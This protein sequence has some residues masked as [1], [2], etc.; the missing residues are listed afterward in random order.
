M[1]ETAGPARAEGVWP[2]RLAL[3]ALAAALY[4]GIPLHR[5]ELMDGTGDGTP[6]VGHFELFARAF[7]HGRIG[8]VVG[9]AATVRIDELIPEHA[10]QAQRPG[11]ET[12]RL[13]QGERLY[14]GYPP[15][16]AFLLIPFVFLF[17][18]VKVQIA[19]RV[20]SVINVMIF[21]A[22]LVRLPCLL[23][24]PP[25]RLSS[26]ILLGLFFAF[27]TAV[28][29]NCKIGGDWHY[30]HAV[31]LCGCLLA[32]HEFAGRNRPLIV[33]LFIACVA[34]TRPTAAVSCAFFALPLIRSRR[35]V[36]LARLAAAPLAA[37]I[38]LGIYNHV[39][40]GSPGDFGYSRM[41][42]TGAGRVAIETHGKFALH[43]V[44]RNF[45]WFFLAPPWKAPPNPILPVAY[46]PRGLSLFLAS[47][48]FLYALFAL[49]RIRAD[50][51]VQSATAALALC[52]VPLL[53]YY[54]AGF[55]Q[56]GH[57]FSMDY[58]AVLMVLTIVGMGPRPGGLAWGLM[59]AAILIQ[60]VG[61]VIDPF[62]HPLLP[63]WLAPSP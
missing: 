51:I 6:Y 37:A 35:W 53:A 61:V 3:A 24:W 52:L 23:G 17:G 33:G 39:R 29:H 12:I 15:L 40:F 9:E 19:C 22:C 58:L 55:W 20:V 18:D 4:F 10:D 25:V 38:G 63:D 7:A 11:D 36:D 34:V 32:L 50:A 1:I 48:A 47:P 42:L 60:A 14:L 5:G 31:A 57:R 13:R 59:I 26:R 27:G 46:D 41:I 45:F 8:L 44:P 21:D 62:V 49:R 56:F 43:F 2:W 16:P 54:N 30:A 28:W